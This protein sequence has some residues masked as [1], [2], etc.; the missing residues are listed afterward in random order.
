[1]KDL[2]FDSYFVS[3]SAYL[4]ARETKAWKIFGQKGKS[5]GSWY[6]QHFPGGPED[7]STK[8]ERCSP[9]DKIYYVVVDKSVVALVKNSW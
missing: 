5:L 9:Y 4:A 1:M 8:A 6:P 2:I 3:A 7:C